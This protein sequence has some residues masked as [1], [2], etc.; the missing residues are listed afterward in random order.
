MQLSFKYRHAFSLL[1]NTHFGRSVKPAAER[2]G[3]AGG[4]PLGRRSGIK[5]DGDGLARLATR[6]AI[7]GSD[8]NPEGGLCAPPP[9]LRAGLPSP[10]GRV[11]LG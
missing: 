7:A 9:Q 11:K 10:P 8:H 4:E 2:R 5:G 3:G 1:K 6:A